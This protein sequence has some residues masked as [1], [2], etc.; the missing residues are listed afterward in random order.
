MCL[1]PGGMPAY[2]VHANFVVIALAAL[3]Y[4]DLVHN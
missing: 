1:N 2:E 4:G 3:Q